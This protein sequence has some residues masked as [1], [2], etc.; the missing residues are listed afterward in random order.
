[1][2]KH[3]YIIGILVVGLVGFAYSQMEF[4]GR[5]WLP[6]LTANARVSDA[7]IAG[8]EFDLVS[9]LGFDDENA[10]EGR[11][12][13][14]ISPRQVVRVAYTQLHYTGDQNINQQII[15]DGQVYNIGTRVVSDLKIQY[16]RAGWIWYFADSGQGKFK[17]GT[18]V[19]AKGIWLDAKLDAPDTVPA[20]SEEK[21]VVVGL[22]TVGLVLDLNPAPMINIFA[23][24]S[25]LTAGD[26]GYCLDAEAGLKFI[27][28]KNLTIFGGYRY[29]DAKGEDE[30][31]NDF[32]KAK[33]KGPFAG[34]T[35]RF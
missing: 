27:P 3:W 24:A 5:Y 4:E 21:E 16:A 14:N 32:V 2:V 19:E 13:W 8:T 23:E 9:D 10:F 34:A 33:L 25:G 1:M 22:P 7:G 31:N 29:L 28:V 6:D 11:L 17:L 30:D 15:F 35:F 12:I 18:L 20:I 26:W